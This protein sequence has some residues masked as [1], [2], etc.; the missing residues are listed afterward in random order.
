MQMEETSRSVVSTPAIKPFKPFIFI[1][2]MTPFFT[3]P[4]FVCL[5][6]VVGRKLRVQVN[7]TTTSK[8]RQIFQAK[9]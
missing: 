7:F 5:D 1:V 3:L 9:C 6:A 8:K 4:H 2:K